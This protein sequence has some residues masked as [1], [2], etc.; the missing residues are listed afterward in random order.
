MAAIAVDVARA[1]APRPEPAPSRR[2]QE[3]RE[4]VVLAASVAQPDEWWQLP[5][6]GWGANEQAAKEDA[7]SKLPADEQ[8]GTFVGI[9]VRSWNPKARTIETQTRP[10]WG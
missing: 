10:R 8:T 4:Y 7:V 2:K 3:P 9:P 5:H 1:D 6:T